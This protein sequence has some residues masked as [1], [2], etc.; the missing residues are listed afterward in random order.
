MERWTKQ[1]FKFR[2]DRFTRRLGRRRSL[3]SLVPLQWRHG[4]ARRGVVEG[5]IAEFRSL[6]QHCLKYLWKNILNSSI[7]KSY[8]LLYSGHYIATRQIWHTSSKCSNAQGFGTPEV[9]R[10]GN[11][12]SVS[13]KILIFLSSPPPSFM[14]NFSYLACFRRDGKFLPLSGDGR[15]GRSMFS[16][17]PMHRSLG[18]PRFESHRWRSRRR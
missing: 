18:T 17:P 2:A 15:H 13:A 5:E 12:D 8:N 10:E 1:T 14:D 6:S 9:E 3:A 16:W 4:R 7:Q 11:T